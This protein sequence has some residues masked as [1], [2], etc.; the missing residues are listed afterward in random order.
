[1]G[2]CSRCELA[3]RAASFFSPDRGPVVLLSAGV[4]ATP[5]FWAMLQRAGGGHPARR[6]HVLW[7]HAARD[8]QH[9]PFT[10]EVRRLMLA[11]PSG[12]SFVCLQQAGFRATK[13]GEDF[14]ATGPSVP[15][16]SSKR[17]A[18]S[19]DADVYLCGP[20]R[21]YVRH[22]RSAHDFGRGAAA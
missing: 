16:P 5:C 13:I 8:G 9:Q 10:A 6:G 7:L 21:F 22:E 19:R 17:S 12:R 4:G 1:V 11:L 20:T 2:E 14:N 18:V 15:D 3:A